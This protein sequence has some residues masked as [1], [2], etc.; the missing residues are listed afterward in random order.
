LDDTVKHSA[1]VH[2]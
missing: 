1:G 2:F